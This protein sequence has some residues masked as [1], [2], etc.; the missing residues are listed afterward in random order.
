M[1]EILKQIEL[2]LSKTT[3]ITCVS[4]SRDRSETIET[5]QVPMMLEDNTIKVLVMPS[6]WTSIEIVPDIKIEM[7]DIL[8]KHFRRSVFA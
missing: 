2:P 4:A 8:L 3:R 5:I 1:W 6:F 7:C